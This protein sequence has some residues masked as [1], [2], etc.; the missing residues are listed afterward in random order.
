MD[1]IAT[2]EPAAT[3]PDELELTFDGIAQGGE[4]VGRWGERVV[5]AAGGLPGE[6]ARVRLHERLPAYAR[7]S[8]TEVLSASPERVEPRLPGASHMPWQHIAFAE[9]GRL[10]RQILADQLAKFAGIAP[11]LVGDTMLASGAWEYRN[12]ARFHCAGRMVG[13][14]AGESQEIVELVADPLLHPALNDALAHLRTALAGEPADAPPVEVTLRVSETYGYCVAALRGRGDRR[15]L[16]AR[17]RAACPALAGVVFTTAPQTTAPP[18]GVDHL[19]E[20]FADIAFLLHPTT[21]FQV[22]IA[23]AQALLDLIRAGLGPMAGGRL[24]DLYCGAGAFTLPLARDAAE[25]VGIEEY[26]GA[27]ADAE[28]TAAAHG[29]ANAYFINA[30]VEAALSDFEGSFDAAV[31]DPPRR[32]CHPRALTMLLELAPRRIVYV[33]CHPATLARDLKTLIGGGY[34]VERATP[35]DLFPQTPHVE[36]VVALSRGTE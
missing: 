15:R 19:V 35:V 26:A 18:L 23:A 9:Q 16:A 12:S 2:S 27:I 20:E 8:V 36:S 22:N 6:R 31:L 3:W 33:S 29:I 30:S 13:Y 21:F 17:W 10:R 4:A 24:L 25:I 7:G 5:F 28:R 32:G 11:A 34:V 14:H 1:K